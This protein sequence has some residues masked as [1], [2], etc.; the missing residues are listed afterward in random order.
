M[1]T[2]VQTTLKALVFVVT[3]LV[4]S[5]AIFVR[6]GFTRQ[7]LVSLAVIAAGSL[8]TWFKANT[9]DFPAAKAVVAVFTTVVAAV[10][11]A[12]SDNTITP[13][14]WASVGLALL[15]AVS[16]YLAGNDTLALHPAT[17]ERQRVV[18]AD[19]TA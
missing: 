9:V 10:V 11:A 15:G 7:E 17:T 13:E 6:N 16:V 18:E 4:G 19:V 2:T 14:E 1:S 3:A 5:S 8:A 12:W